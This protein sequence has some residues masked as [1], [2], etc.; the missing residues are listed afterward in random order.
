MG[1]YQQQ[2]YIGELRERNNRKV[3][4]LGS[5]VVS[6][7]AKKIYEDSIILT[8]KRTDIFLNNIFF[9]DTIENRLM[10]VLF[11]IDYESKNIPVYY[12]DNIR[13]TTVDVADDSIR[14]QIAKEKM[15]NTN[16]PI[17]LSTMTEDK[18]EFRN[19]IFDESKLKRHLLHKNETIELYPTAIVEH[20][21]FVRLWFEDNLLLDVEYLINTIPQPFFGPLV[22]DD[23]LYE[24]KP[25]VFVSFKTNEEDYMTYSYN[26]CFWKRIFVKRGNKCIEF[27]EKDWDENRFKMYFPDVIDYT[28]TKIPYGRISSVIINDTKRIKHVGRFAQWQHDITNE[29]IIHKLINLNLK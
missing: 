29:H 26:N 14:I 24:Y 16:K 7:F 9:H 10:L 12:Y 1:S 21:D 6:T 3:A 2:Q 13:H 18:P 22:E 11:G 5:G 4:I 17:I 23:T 8:K 28:V 19:L 27:D 20:E 15:G 25:L